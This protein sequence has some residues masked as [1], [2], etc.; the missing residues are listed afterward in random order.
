MGYYED[1]ISA[2]E[3]RTETFGKN[4]Q[5]I[6]DLVSFLSPL[7]KVSSLI[8][9]ILLAKKTPAQRKPFHLYFT[10]FLIEWKEKGDS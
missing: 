8:F 3:D 9:M 2:K 7:E 5:E 1:R 10:V 6:L 4:V